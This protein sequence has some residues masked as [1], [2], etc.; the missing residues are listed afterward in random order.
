MLFFKPNVDKLRKKRDT[1]G[2][3]RVIRD[4]RL[5]ESLRLDAVRALAEFGLDQSQALRD[6]AAD[7]SLPTSIRQNAAL[8]VGHILIQQNQTDGFIESKQ[9]QNLRFLIGLLRTGDLGQPVREISSEALTTAVEALHRRNTA[10]KNRAA[11]PSGLSRNDL[12][13]ILGASENPI[14]A[15]VLKESLSVGVGDQN[16]WGRYEFPAAVNGALAKVLPENSAQYLAERVLM[17]LNG[18]GDEK[19]D[20][21]KVTD[22][23]K[24]IGALAIPT[25]R[26]W[27][28]KNLHRQGGRAAIVAIKGMPP[29]I[30]LP[31][32]EDALK[33]SH[34]TVRSFA[35]DYLKQ[36]GESSACRSLAAKNQS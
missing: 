14:V 8:A 19:L 20:A 6:A 7:V 28:A 10:L 3:D 25:I 31:V 36:H 34:S 12:V 15:D 23:V 21:Y 26:D 5:P 35:I 2:L 1:K 29:D 30:A 33:S 18:H 24:P 32:V 11:E 17:F 16:Q 4:S 22:A 9:A 27:L 13:D